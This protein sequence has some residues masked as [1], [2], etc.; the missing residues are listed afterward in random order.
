MDAP[1]PYRRAW[2]TR[3]LDE[4]IDELAE[5]VVL[6]S[7]M[8]SEPFRGRGAAR[9]L[10]GVLFD[11]LHDVEITHEL[12]DGATHAFF[13]RANVTGG[14]I[15]GADLIRGDAQGKIDEI[16]VL[17]RPLRSIAAFAAATGPPLAGKRGRLRRP[18]VRVM[19]L[20]LRA[21]LS[22]VDVLAARLIHR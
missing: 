19:T 7:P 8:I 1:H 10:F 17:I 18:L 15:E 13:W 6:H 5:D 16:T 20:P 22:L 4:W 2:E 11:V 21:L 12:T 14:A 9:E 3:D